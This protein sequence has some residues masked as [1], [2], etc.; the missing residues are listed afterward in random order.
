M[1]VCTFVIEWCVETLGEQRYLPDTVKGIN[2]HQLA[3]VYVTL[4]IV[5][6]REKCT[7]EHHVAATSRMYL[8]LKNMDYPYSPIRLL[9]ATADP[10]PYCNG[11]N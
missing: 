11:D 5:Y 7:F 10:A 1:K 2:S 9:M 6:I 3:L 8:T 4:K